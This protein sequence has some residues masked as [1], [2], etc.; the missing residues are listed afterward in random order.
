MWLGH[1][2]RMDQ[3]RLPHAIFFTDVP[4]NWKRR[5][6]GHRMT[7]R[8]LVEDK[9]LGDELVLYK[10]LMG[11]DFHSIICDLSSNRKQWRNLVTG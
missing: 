9:A 8:K 2:A 7:W 4:D 5:P 1:V 6:G 11:Y 3:Q 10:R